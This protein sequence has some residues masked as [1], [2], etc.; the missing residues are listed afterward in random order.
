MS[1]SLF[2]AALGYRHGLSIRQLRRRLYDN[3]IKY[4][5]EDRLPNAATI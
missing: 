4:T 3:K 2:L 5:I 1:E